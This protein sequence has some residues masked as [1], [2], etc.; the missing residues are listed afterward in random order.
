MIT[1]WVKVREKNKGNGY[2]FTGVLTL[3]GLQSVVF[4]CTP[5]TGGFP[6]LLWTSGLGSPPSSCL[7]AISDWVRGEQVPRLGPRGRSK[8]VLA[9]SVNVTLALCIGFKWEKIKYEGA[10]WTLREGLLRMKPSA[11]RRTGTW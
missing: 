1:E 8:E 9:S 7:E 10:V 2:G 6:Y 3:P 11:R 4:V 5:L